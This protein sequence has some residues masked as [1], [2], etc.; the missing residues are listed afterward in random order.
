MII[1]ERSRDACQG[2]KRETKEKKKKNVTSRS[3][4]IRKLKFEDRTLLKLDAVLFKG[5]KRMEDPHI[6]STY[7]IRRDI[8][9]VAS[10][11]VY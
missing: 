5:W 4:E 11:V 8:G 7:L 9:R 1:C 10:E 2:K 6:P 3:H